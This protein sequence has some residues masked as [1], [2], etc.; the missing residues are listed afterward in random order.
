MYSLKINALNKAKAMKCSCSGEKCGK[1]KAVS[2]ALTELF[3]LLG[4]SSFANMIS[5]KRRAMSMHK[6]I[7]HDKSYNAHPLAACVKNHADCIEVELIE[8]K[9]DYV[10]ILVWIDIVATKINSFFVSNRVEQDLT[11]KYWLG[12]FLEFVDLV[13]IIDHQKEAAR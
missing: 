9:P 6:D 11:A 2:I 7:A 5:A 3:A 4:D 13:L 8:E 12:R 10:A 1:A